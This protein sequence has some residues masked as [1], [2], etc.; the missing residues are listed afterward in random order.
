MV[1]ACALRANLKPYLVASTPD[2]SSTIAAR[3]SYSNS[4]NRHGQIRPA[5]GKSAESIQ[6]IAAAADLIS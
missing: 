2:G 3:K 5:T 6:F 1:P 4:P